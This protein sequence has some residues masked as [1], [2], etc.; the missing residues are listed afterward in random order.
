MATQAAYYSAETQASSSIR[1]YV[2][3]MKPGVMLLVVFTGTAGILMAP[4][5]LPPLLKLVTVLCIAMGSGAGGAINMWY[6]R[7]IDALMKRTA[8]R[9]VPAGR[10]AP[11]DA[12]MFG[13]ILAIASVLLLG[14]AVSWGAAWLLAFSIWFYAGVY[15]MILKRS[16]PQNIVIGGAAG[17][18]PPVIGWLAVTPDVTWEPILY[19]L[20][21]FFWTPPHFWALALYRSQDYRRSG[22]PMLPVTAGVESTKQHILG[23]S[24][25]LAFAALLPAL[26]GA[27]HQVYFAA[28]ATLSAI[29][30]RYVWRVYTS[31]EPK[32][33]MRLFAFSINYLFLLFS[34]L[35]LDKLLTPII[36]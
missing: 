15:T 29:F 35:V 21:I 13:I 14:L 25:V 19:F 32:E 27:A 23:Y 17:A 11:G 18:F 10:I 20:I 28:S 7:D 26:T 5:N 16:T 36:N 33:A 9:P 6:D 24:V 22:V 31:D 8:T 1:D 34:A 12:L 3:L 2:T 4:G 30:L